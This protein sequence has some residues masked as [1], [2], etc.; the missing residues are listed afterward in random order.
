VQ[1][2]RNI[3]IALFIAMLWQSAGSTVEA[4][5]TQH[6]P[7]E[8]RGSVELERAGLTISGGDAEAVHVAENCVLTL[9]DATLSSKAT[10]VRVSGNG[11]LRLEDVKVEGSTSVEL[12][13]NAVVRAR[14]SSFTGRVKRLHN[15]RF[16][17]LGGNRYR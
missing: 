12:T 5:S 8:C 6:S 11:E 1:K 17:D 15:G 16:V 13:S 9:R 7:I 4:E 10:A 14:N 3:L 2:R